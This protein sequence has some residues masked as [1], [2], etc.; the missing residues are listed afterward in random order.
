MRM[1]FS[2]KQKNDFDAAIA[3]LE[4]T[5]K[6]KEATM[7]TSL[8]DLFVDVL[9]YPKTSIVVDTAGTRG[10]P[11]ISVFAPGGATGSRVS[12]IVGEVKDEHGAV[13]NPANRVALF[14]EK[15][16]YI[17]ADTAYFIMAD[18]Q[19]LVFRGVGLGPQA[20]IEVP[21]AGLSIEAF[22]E[23]LAPLRSEV[24]GVPEML[25]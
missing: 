2:A 15:A 22:A 4:A 14:A 21:W 24:A 7:Y 17:T 12:W 20:D 18:P 16:K 9:G 13:A 10:R 19:M 25:R 11:D 6:G 23:V 8:R 3:S 5:P 1:S